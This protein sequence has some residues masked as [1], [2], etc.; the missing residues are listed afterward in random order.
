M[1]FFKYNQQTINKKQKLLDE[2]K[3]PKLLTK[4][5]LN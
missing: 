4:Q 2:T 5:I 3:Q 1:F